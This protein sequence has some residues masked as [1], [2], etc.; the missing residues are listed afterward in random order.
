MYK[1]KDI[2]RNNFLRKVK[3]I[4]GKHE[5]GKKNYRWTKTVAKGI[6][7]SLSKLYVNKSM[8][9]YKVHP[10]ILKYLSPNLRFI[11]VTSRF[12]EKCI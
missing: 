6:K 4:T 2:L 8:G 3:S 1:E 12:F 11:S 5:E 10:N 7:L 9:L